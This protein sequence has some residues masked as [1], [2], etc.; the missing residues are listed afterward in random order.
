MDYENSLTNEQK[1]KIIQ[2]LLKKGHTL[3]KNEIKQV[4]R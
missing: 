2:E 4:L 3:K 1:I